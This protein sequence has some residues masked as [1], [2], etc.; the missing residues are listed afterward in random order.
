[1]LNRRQIM[2]A[3]G[4]AT[5]GGAQALTAMEAGAQANRFSRITLRVGGVTALGPEV[6]L[7]AAGLLDGVPYRLSFVKFDSGSHGVEALNAGA[8]DTLMAGDGPAIVA[9]SNPGR[10]VVVGACTTTV[11]SDIIVP[12]TSRLRSVADLRGK[13]VA[14]IRASTQQ[15]LLE[16]ALLAAGIPW[17]AIN[18]IYLSAPDTL[19]AF[20]NGSIDAWSANDPNSAMATLRHGARALTTGRA[21]PV[22]YQ[23][24]YANVA[25]LKDPLLAL[26]IRDHTLR[27]TKASRWTRLYPD[28]W[29]EASERA[30]KMGKDVSQLVA[31]RGGGGDFRSIDAQLTARIQ[32]MANHFA[33]AGIL[34]R[35]VDVARVMDGRFNAFLNNHLKI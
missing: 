17:R 10:V 2:M 28:A 16:Q 34:P 21:R 20:L 9:A 19:A 26:V 4:G 25:S 1:M 13:R 7:R 14:V 8:I 5:F 35:K 18:P 31:R 24:Q 32:L 30:V 27:M 15:Y 11:Y 29:A 33:A 3:L 23:F 6:R 12:R 22:T